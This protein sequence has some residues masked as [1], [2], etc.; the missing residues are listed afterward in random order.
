MSLHG[1]TERLLCKAVKVNPGL[2]LKPQDAGDVR[3][4]GHL[5]RTSAK[6][7]WNQPKRE[8]RRLQ[9]SKLKGVRVMVKMS[10]YSN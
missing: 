9:S 3:V 10:L 5:P 7:V 1:D 6:M 4:V 8:R 2:C